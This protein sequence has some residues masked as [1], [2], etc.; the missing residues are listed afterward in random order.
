MA[1]MVGGTA[2]GQVQI[3][4]GPIKPPIPP[5][6]QRQKPKKKA[7]PK[8]QV[9]YYDVTFTCNAYDADLYIDG[10]YVGDANTIWTLK[11]G[12]HAVKV[13]TN[14]YNDYSTTVN[15]SGS[16]SVDLNLT[17]KTDAESQ[18]QLGVNYCEGRSG[19]PQDYTESVK[20]IRNAADKGFARAQNWL[21]YCYQIG[22]GVTQSY[23][24]AFNW[25]KKAAEQG[26][27][28]AQCNLGW[29]YQNG[30]GVTQSYSEAV[31]W[32]NK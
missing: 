25:Y 19:F 13:V 9:K 3:Q 4:G 14:Y 5:A 6:K 26:Y 28:T 31:K 20:R 11:A 2:V 23:T 27:A 24:E 29:F 15:V 10:D 1:L 12:S 32:Y 22:E 17:E 7:R 30:Y 8:K 16:K 21:G 18:F